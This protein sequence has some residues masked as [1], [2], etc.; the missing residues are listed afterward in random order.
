MKQQKKDTGIVILGGLTYIFV[1]LMVGICPLFVR[2]KFHD[3]LLAKVDFI[4]VSAIVFIILVIITEIVRKWIWKEKL[5]YGKRVTPEMI[6]SGVFLVAAGFSAI[7]GG[8]LAE[9]FWGNS[10]RRF[11]MFV[12]LL[13]IAVYFIIGRYF[14]ANTGLIWI[15]LIA[16]SLV[17][18]IAILNFWGVDPLGM[19][20]GAYT[21][22]I[23]T[24]G[25]INVYSSYIC[26]ILPIAMVL[27]FLC[28]TTFS[29]VTY[30]IFLI[31]GFYGAYATNS[32]SWILGIGV[33]FIVL[34][35]FGLKNAETMKKYYQLWGLFFLASLLIKTTIYIGTI[36]G[37]TSPFIKA[38]SGMKLQNMMINGYVLLVEGILLILLLMV[39]RG[40]KKEKIKIHY[41]KWRKIIFL[42]IGLCI[43]GFL[44]LVT[45]VNILGKWEDGSAL[46]MLLL[47]D[48]FGSGRGYIWKFTMRMFKE[49]SLIR[50]IFGCGMNDF[51]NGISVEYQ[52]EILNR[53]GARLLDAH[54]EFL[55]YLVTTGVA[56][57]AGYFG[58]LFYHLYSWWK[59]YAENPILIMGIV[60]LCSYF[61]QGLVNNPQIFITACL[62]V[63]LGIMKSI[64]RRSA[65][66]SI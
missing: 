6:F 38:F 66:N 65:I 45:V 56:G 54:N 15:Y 42:I 57:V 24:M 14:Q 28:D 34:L 41:F 35:W 12:M 23:G 31:I 17:L 58:F 10:G 22:F 16:N 48:E 27:Y 50:Q 25:N 11:G 49:Q 62:F 60:T 18:S 33:S 1:V 20:D 4:R 43:C 37:I 36:F 44:I 55:Q 8:N 61:A 59:K 3:I 13:L 46:G 19:Y 52:T 21:I 39:N 32:D 2:N 53:L 5:D 64:E 40:A 51:W 9:S 30:G 63:F 29:K 26:L 47:T 7:Y